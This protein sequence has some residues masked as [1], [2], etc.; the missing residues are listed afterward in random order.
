VNILQVTE[1]KEHTLEV[2]ALASASD[3]S[4]AWDL[5][6]DIR[7]RLVGFLQLNY[8]E[9]LPKI[10]ASFEPVGTLTIDRSSDDALLDSGVGEPLH[11]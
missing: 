6:C 11:R 4:L 7:E 10:R 1:A 8:P 3:A 2:R 9:S 5:R